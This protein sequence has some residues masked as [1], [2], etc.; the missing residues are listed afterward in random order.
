V[1]PAEHLTGLAAAGAI[2]LAV[3]REPRQMEARWRRFLEY[4]VDIANGGNG[5]ERSGD[6]TG[7]S[8]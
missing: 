3:A 2:L 8:A 5:R 1:P 7:R 4:G 6:A